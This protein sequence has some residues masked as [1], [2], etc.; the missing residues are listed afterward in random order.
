VEKSQGLGAWATYTSGAYKQY[1]GQQTTIKGYGG[2]RPGGQAAG[3]Q[4]TGVPQLFDQYLSLRDMPRTAPPNTKNPFQYFAASFTGNWENLGM[5][6][7]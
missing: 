5:P 1:L 6:N 3:Q 4:Q 2:T 7:K